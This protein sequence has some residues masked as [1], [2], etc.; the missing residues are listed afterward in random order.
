MTITETDKAVGWRP[1]FREGYGTT[2]DVY[3]WHAWSTANACLGMGLESP[4]EWCPVP[5]IA[6]MRM[7]RSAAWI[8]TAQVTTDLGLCSFT[9]RKRT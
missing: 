2:D 1:F 4:T 6:N 3:A 5:G 9:W 7:Y 8:V